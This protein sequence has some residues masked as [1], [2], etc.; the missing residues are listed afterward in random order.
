LK[1]SMNRIFVR[2]IAGQLLENVERDP[3]H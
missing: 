2:P 1:T 3:H